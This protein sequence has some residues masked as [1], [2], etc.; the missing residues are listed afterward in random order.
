MRAIARR[1][2]GAAG[3]SEGGARAGGI[4]I[5]ERTVRGGLGVA[6][7]SRGARPHH[8]P[9]RRPRSRELPA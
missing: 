1:E 9:S 4:E 6:L 5:D 7:S 2:A 3:R 8:G